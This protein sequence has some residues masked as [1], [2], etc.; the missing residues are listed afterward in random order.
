MLMDMSLYFRRIWTVDPW[1]GLRVISLGAPSALVGPTPEGVCS[2]CKQLKTLMLPG[3]SK[4][5]VC[6]G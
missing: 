1:T 6:S 4:E 3:G 2:Q 5:I